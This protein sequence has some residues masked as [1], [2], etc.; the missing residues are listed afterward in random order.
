MHRSSLFLVVSISFGASDAI[1]CGAERPAQPAPVTLTAQQD[2][3]NMLD[4][5]KIPAAAMRRGPSGWDPKAPDYQNT[6]EARANPWPHLPEM[7]VTR[8]RKKVD[9][10][11]RGLEKIRSGDMTYRELSA[12]LAAVNN[13][14]KTYAAI[15]RHIKERFKSIYAELNSKEDQEIFIQDLNREVQ[16]RGIIRGPVPHQVYEE[17]ILDIRKESFYLNNLLP[18][19]IVSR[20][21]RLREDFLANSGLDRFYVESLER[22]YF[23]MNQ[24]DAFILEEIRT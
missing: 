10:L 6:D 16:A 9:T 21:N 24:I 19:I 1:V 2:R 20:D 23:D 17:I 22:D 7:M 12:L 3:Q 4:Q 5:L 13:E 18:H 11:Y 8:G 15:H 14:E